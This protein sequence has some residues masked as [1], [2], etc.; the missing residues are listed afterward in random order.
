[1][2]GTAVRVG[3]AYLRK[4]NNRKQGSVGVTCILKPMPESDSG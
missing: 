3:L 1:M 4:T 2:A